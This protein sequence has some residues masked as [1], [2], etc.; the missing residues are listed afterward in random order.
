[1]TLPRYFTAKLLVGGFLAVSGYGLAFQGQLPFD[2]QWDT[3]GS[4]ASAGAAALGSVL[5]DD[6][7]SPT[8]LTSLGDDLTR[9]W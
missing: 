2:E 4:A 8:E 1:M 9:G 6:V 7:P 3:V 5:P